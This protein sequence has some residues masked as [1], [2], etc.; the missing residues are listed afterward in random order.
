MEFFPS[1]GPSVVA[2]TVDLLFGGNK[3]ALILDA[4][5]GT[6]VGGKELQNLG[7]TNLEALD[8]CQAMLDIANQRGVYNRTICDLL[9]PN[10]LDVDSGYYD[11]VVCVGAMAAG[12]ANAGCLPELIR[13]TKSGGYVVIAT[14]EIHIPECGYDG[15]SWDDCLKIHE[16]NGLWK[17]V[18]IKKV[19]DYFCDHI[20][21]IFIYRIM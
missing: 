4:G 8:G 2:R 17:K 18:E 20:G 11:C 12:N 16:D 6:G 9:G 1:K 21:I 7:F 14:R 5:A 15:K 10:R 19:E 13:I 3:D